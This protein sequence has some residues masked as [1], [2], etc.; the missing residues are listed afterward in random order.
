MRLLLYQCFLSSQLGTFYIELIIAALD[1]V[2]I[3]SINQETFVESATFHFVQ[4]M[5][6]RLSLD[7]DKTKCDGNC[8][9]LCREIFFVE[10]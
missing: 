2:L 8:Q 5:G 10:C 3:A 6:T 1:I 7:F 4:Q 9:K